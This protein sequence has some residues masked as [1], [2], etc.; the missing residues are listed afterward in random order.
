MLVDPASP[1]PNPTPQEQ[2]KAAAQPQLKTARAQQFA[3]NLPSFDWRA[4]ACIAA[5]FLLVSFGRE[6]IPGVNEHCYLAKAKHLVNPAWCPQDAFLDSSNPHFVYS[7]LMGWLLRVVSLPT[8]AII[9]RV[10]GNLILAAGWTV[11]SQRLFIP[12]T[13]SR[14]INEDDDVIQAQPFL[15]P[16][17][18]SAALFALLQSLL[19]WSGEWVLGGTESKVFS[20]GFLFWG[21]G[22][23]AAAHDQ[24]IGLVRHTGVCIPWLRTGIL[25][26]LAISFHPVVGGWGAIL[27]A[28]AFFAM[29]LRELGHVIANP[30]FEHRPTDAPHLALQWGTLA[31]FL[32]VSLIMAAPGLYFALPALVSPTPEIARI[33]DNLQLA[34]RLRHHLDPWSFG[35]KT[36]LAYLGM[37]WL[38]WFLRNFSIFQS[39]RWSTRPSPL[40]FFD[41]FVVSAAV[42]AAGGV[43]CARGLIS[44]EGL[45]A[46]SN[47]SLRIRFLKIYPFRLADLFV[48]LALSMT[49]ASCIGRGHWRML[50]VFIVPHRTFRRTALWGL[51]VAMAGLAVVVPGPSRRSRKP[52]PLDAD[53]REACAWL[54]ENT[55][56][57]ALVQAADQTGGIRGVTALK[58][59]AER[60]EYTNWKDFPQDAASIAKWND[61]MWILHYWGTA[62]IVDQEI[63]RAEL[64]QLHES[65]KI[66]YLVL[67]AGNNKTPAPVFSNASFQIFRLAQ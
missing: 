13:R 40:R 43:L 3:A 55:P 20:Y 39:R 2:G 58:W 66:E 37:L 64:A 49:L 14:D 27:I 6:P 19:N 25:L 12:R 5:V 54:R 31:K 21:L 52:S 24:V 62:A 11:L 38:W 67:K 1:E 4:W 65:T 44:A 50:P 56:P 26:G 36:H 61:R 53:W 48:P 16:T 10:L 18:A 28:I 42:V 47:A 41:L 59:F 35:Q 46:V 32:T 9:G 33:A 8:G 17:A 22:E 60:P 30:E 57:D 23:A 29:Y 7:W 63:D 51:V 15:W 34:F 45:N